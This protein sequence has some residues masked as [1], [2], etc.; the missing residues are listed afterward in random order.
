[1]I[2]SIGK[3]LRD[4]PYSHKSTKLRNHKAHVEDLAQTHMEPMF[5]ASVSEPP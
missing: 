1:M 3:R 4:T 2:L 5:T